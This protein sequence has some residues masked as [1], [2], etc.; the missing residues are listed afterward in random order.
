MREMRKMVPPD[1]LVGGGKAEQIFQD[2]LD[3]ELAGELART[4]QLGLA[5]L[6]FQDMQKLLKQTGGNADIST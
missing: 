6:I 4:N 2:F 5:E 3:E 1:P